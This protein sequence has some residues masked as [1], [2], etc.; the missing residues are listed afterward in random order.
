MSLR[1]AVIAAAF[2]LLSIAVVAGAALVWFKHAPRRT[3]S[4]Q[5]ALSRLDAPTLPAFR[6]AFNARAD[7]RRIVVLL[8]PT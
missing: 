4:G 3:P 7:E 5:P 1:K 2:A 6:E 8:S